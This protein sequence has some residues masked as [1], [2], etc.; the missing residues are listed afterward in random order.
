MIINL[1]EEKNKTIFI[2]SHILK[3][4]EIIASRMII[5]NRGKTVVEGSV[6]DLLN[7]EEL[8]VKFDVDDTEKT[9][10][11][12]E[13][14]NWKE[15]FVETLD[16]SLIFELDHEEVDDATERDEKDDHQPVVRFAPSDRVHQHPDLESDKGE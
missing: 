9:I 3:E 5:I 1:S 2:S 11:I 6:E 7:A 12:I 16:K 8:K 14:S 13:Q 10:E 4:I 15:K